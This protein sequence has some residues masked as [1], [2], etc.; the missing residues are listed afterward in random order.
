LSNTW[1]SG[2]FRKQNNQSNSKVENKKAYF[3]TSDTEELYELSL[4]KRKQLEKL[5]PNWVKFNCDKNYDELNE[6]YEFF[7]KN[8]KLLGHPKFNNV[9]VGLTV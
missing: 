8:G 1:R 4:S 5:Y 3:V 2:E 6:V 9:F 7:K